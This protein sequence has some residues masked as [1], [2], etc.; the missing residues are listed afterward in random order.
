MDEIREVS[1]TGSESQRRPQQGT[2]DPISDRPPNKTPRFLIVPNCP[3]EIQNVNDGLWR[4]HRTTIET[5]HERFET[6]RDK[7]YVFRRY[8][9]LIRIHRRYVVHRED[10]YESGA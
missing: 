7:H 9:Y 6:Y 1:W 3:C 10:S 4:P 8:G 2:C 5:G